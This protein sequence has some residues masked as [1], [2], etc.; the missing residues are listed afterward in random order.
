MAWTISF[1][2]AA[3]AE[4]LALPVELQARLER[5][6]KLIEAYGLQGLPAKLAPHIQGPVWEFRLKD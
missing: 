2:Q 6:A 3:R 1:H 5:I 4:F